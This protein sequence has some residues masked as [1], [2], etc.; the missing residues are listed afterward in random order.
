MWICGQLRV[1][2]SVLVEV[3]RF[4]LINHDTQIL[5]AI[6]FGFCHYFNDDKSNR[7]FVFSFKV[8]TCVFLMF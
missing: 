4:K 3:V 7:P 5:Q 1:P 6:S 8:I 2:P